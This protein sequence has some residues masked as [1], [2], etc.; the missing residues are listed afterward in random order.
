MKA[1]IK[2]IATAMVVIFLMGVLFYGLVSFVAVITTWDTDMLSPSKWD[3][4]IRFLYAMATIVFGAMG[5]TGI[6]F[7]IE[8]TDDD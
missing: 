1:L 4:L 6:I 7:H 3:P 5:T 2:I 8:V